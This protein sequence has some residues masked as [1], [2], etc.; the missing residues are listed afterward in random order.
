M[1]HVGIFF[2]ATIM[3]RKR[4]KKNYWHNITIVQ[5]SPSLW[6]SNHSKEEKSLEAFSPRLSHV[7]QSTDKG[8]F[9]SRAKIY[10]ETTVLHWEEGEE[11]KKL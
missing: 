2:S 6:L 5:I 4:K 1:W 8:N 9:E 7:K 10:K 11:L 3:K